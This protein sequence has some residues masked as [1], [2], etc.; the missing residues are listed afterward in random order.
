MSRIHSYPSVYA[1]GHRALSELLLD[2]VVVQEKVDGSQIS[3]AVFEEGMGTSGYLYSPGER[4]LHVRSKGAEIQVLAPDKMFAKGVAAIQVVASELRPGWIYR[5]EYLAKPKHN[6]LAYDRIPK[7]NIVLFDVEAGDQDFLPPEGVAAEAERLWF[8]YIPVLFQGAVKSIE[9]FRELLDT[10]SFLGGQKIEGVVVKNYARFG[11]DKKVLMGKFVSEAFKEVHA[12]EWKKENPN[13][14]DVIEMLI[15]MY[16]TPARFQK[17]VQHLR[18]LGVLEDSPRDIGLLFKE[19]PDD[20]EKECSDEIK[21]KLWVWAWPKLRRGVTAGLAL[22][23]KEEL[24][25]RQF[26][27]EEERRF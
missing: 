7:N 5:G 8:D 14:G 6:A 10:P 3:F 27:A 26:N 21:N 4:V 17:A 13:Q 24:L 11:L 15:S 9:F 22:W 1:M 18:E 23:Y 25:K 20:V 12:A 2:T 19:V 16:H